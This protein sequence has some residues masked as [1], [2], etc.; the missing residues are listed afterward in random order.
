M[1]QVAVLPA[2]FPN[3]KQKVIEND[4]DLESPD[5]S[6]SAS[7]LA[8][9]GKSNSRGL[10]IQSNRPV[11]QLLSNMPE[12]SETESET[13]DEDETVASEQSKLRRSSRSPTSKP[14]RHSRNNIPPLDQAPSPI[15]ERDVKAGKV[16]PSKVSALADEL[17]GL[18]L[19]ADREKERT[20]QHVDPD[21]EEDSM[22]LPPKG[23]TKKGQ[24]KKR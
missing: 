10:E 2:F 16:R 23:T 24:T 17:D 11:K 8:G 14:D 1:R 12:E 18:S 19:S 20:E 9:K 5:R 22:I 4:D 6:L 3:T 7:P 21:S 13:E 15:F